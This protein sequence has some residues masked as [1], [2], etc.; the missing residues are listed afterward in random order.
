MS[1]YPAP[2]GQQGEIFNPSLWIVS[3]IT[4]VS[5]Q[6]LDEN[7]LRYPVAQ[8][9]ETLNGITNLSNGTF[10]KNIVM[11]GTYL[12]NYIEFPDGSQQ[13]TA[14]SGGGSGDA[15]LSGGTS[16]T[17]QVFT[18][19]NA[20]NNTGGIIIEDSTNTTTTTTLYQNGDNLSINSS[21][22]GGGVQLGDT[23]AFVTLS[24]NGSGLALNK[25]ITVSNATNSNI[26]LL[27]SDAT[28]NKQLDITGQVSIGNTTSSNTVVLKSD[29][30]TTGQLDVVGSCAIGGN[31]SVGNSSNSNTVSLS[32]DAGN[33]N[34]LNITNSSINI[35][36][37]G[38]PILLAGYGDSDLGKYGLQVSGGGIFVG[39]NDGAADSS[40]FVQIACGETADGTLMVYGNLN[41]TG[42][43]ITLNGSTF[44]SGTTGLNIGQPITLTSNLVLQGTVS[45]DTTSSTLSQS[46]NIV[47]TVQYDGSIQ[48]YGGTVNRSIYLNYTG[49]TDL[50][51]QQN[52][53][54]YLQVS[55]GL[56]LFPNKYLYPTS[57]NFINMEANGTT[58]N[59]LDI[60]GNL[61]TTGSII[62]GSGA[63]TPQ[64]YLKFGNGSIQTVAYT[65]GAPILATYTS[66]AL[67][68]FITPYT[69]SFTGISNSLGNQVNWILYSNSSITVSSG[70]TV[71]TD[72][73]LLVQP[74]ALNNYIFGSGTAIQI[75]YKYSDGTTTTTQPTYYPTAVV[76]LGGFT[77]SA[78]ADASVNSTFRVDL[79]SDTNTAFTNGSTLTLKI[80]AN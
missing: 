42:T 79:N 11:T 48:L 29:A 31:L 47:E 16:T 80:Y 78:I 34:Q 67:D 57:T 52:Y 22:A 43:S 10:E 58:N 45:G 71:Y 49:Q 36:G 53:D 28:T 17:P 7:Y 19:V 30:T 24:T 50:Q 33:A 76:A 75:P 66:T 26:V 56:T 35:A 63:S 62:L 32:A 2:T 39:N 60:L 70:S 64:A 61:M 25:G 44:T 65:G 55:S 69:W 6:Y 3:A 54:E 20:F 51:I 21:I 8:G 59:Q 38:Y 5:V 23:T 41:I 18:G 74:S 15:Q 1:V 73:N 68:T 12:T 9:Y 72:E 46:T 13:F 14:D 27:K 40:Y 77:L 4:G 37:A